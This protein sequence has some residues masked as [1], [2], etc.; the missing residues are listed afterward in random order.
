M[1]ELPNPG[2]TPNQTMDLTGLD[3]SGDRLWFI[4]SQ[5]GTRLSPDP[6]LSEAENLRRLT[7]MA[8]I[9]RRAC[10]GSVRLQG[11]RLPEPQDLALL[12][13]QEDGQEGGNDL[14]RAL[15]KDPHLGPCAAPGGMA[16]A[17]HGL[18]VAGLAARSGRV[19]VGLSGSV[20]GGFAVLLELE[21]HELRRCILDLNPIGLGGRPYRKHLIDL[22]GL[23]VRALRWRGDDLLILSGP[24]PCQPSHRA[25]GQPGIYQVRGAISLGDDSLTLAGDPRLELIQP[26]AAA[27][28]GESPA[29]MELYDG[30][31]Q[32]G[33][34]VAYRNPLTA[35]RVAPDGVLADV[36][37][38]P[39]A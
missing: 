29:T 15:A 17:D 1:F 25:A 31:G 18:T 5:A 22:K 21:P 33:V 9:A 20:L 7:R 3:R 26:L 28:E 36:F 13:I 8:P 30:L 24:P 4:G 10:L 12:P 32:P 27:P 34:M 23:G 19:W 35:R 39:S 14:L 6:D 16:T 38:L 2:E 37:T 11:E